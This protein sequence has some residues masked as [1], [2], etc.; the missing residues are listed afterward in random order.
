VTTSGFPHCPRL[1][2]TL[3]PTRLCL[4]LRDVLSLVDDVS[5]DAVLVVFAINSLAFPPAS[6]LGIGMDLRFASY[7]PAATRICF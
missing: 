2:F 5:R 4:H 7:N 3:S 1:I 6:P